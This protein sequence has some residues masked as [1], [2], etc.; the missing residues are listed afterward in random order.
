MDRREILRRLIDEMFD[1]KQA[2]F[3]RAI[4]KSPAQVNQW[5]TGHRALGDAGARAIELALNLGTGYFDQTNPS[6]TVARGPLAPAARKVWVIGN[7]QGGLPDR[8]WTDGDYPVGASDKYAEE[9]TDDA[10]AFIVKVHGDS[11]SPRY[12]PGEYVLVEPSVPPDLEDD[13]LVR[14]A[15][16]ETM[17]KRLLSRRG[18]IKLGSWNSPEIMSFDERDVSW[19]YYISNRVPSHK[20]KLWVHV[21]E[22][23]GEERRCNEG[24]HEPERRADPPKRP[25]TARTYGPQPKQPPRVYGPKKKTGNDG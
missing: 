20:I 17:I 13:V 9:Q 15:T 5:L 14:L 10:H 1:G 12:M 23:E 7:G 22:Y 19:M 8:L 3:A 25:A 18:G 24:A 2:P 6:P 4:K 16:G 11:M 21:E